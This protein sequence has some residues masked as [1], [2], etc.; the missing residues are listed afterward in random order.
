MIA[1]AEPK[2][3]QS[4]CPT[5]L[6]WQEVLQAFRDQAEPWYLDR[7]RYRLQGRMWGTGRPLYFL[8]GMTGSLELYALL[9]WLLREDFRCVLWD[10][11]DSGLEQAPLRNWS[12][13]EAVEDVAAVADCLGDAQPDLFA[14][15]FGTLVA[16]QLMASHPA[17]VGRAVF[18]AAWAHRE[19]SAFERGLL[20]VGQYAPGRLRH[21]LGAG[22]IQRFNHREWFPPFDQTRWRF[23]SENTGHTLLRSLVIRGGI[24]QTSDLRAIL[25]QVRQPVLLIH[26]EGEG[27]VDTRCADVLRSGLPNARTE[28]LYNSG[29]LSF[30]THPHRLAKLVRGFLLPEVT[31]PADPG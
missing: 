11:P 18:Q 25:P 28:S 30:L 4:G 1:T 3:E 22:V 17:R 19:Y 8:N 29:K 20:A 26:A 7:P 31:T 9:V 2:S 21:V 23:L 5:P 6:E 15:S 10:Y 16:L 13:S 24:S 12:L 27:P 14:A